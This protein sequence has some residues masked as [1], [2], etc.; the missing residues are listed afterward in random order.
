[1]ADTRTKKKPA[2][3]PAPSSSGSSD[4]LQGLSNW[5]QANVYHPANVAA[6]DTGRWL[7][8]EVAEPSERTGAQAGRGLA[9][10]VDTASNAIGQI[11]GIQSLSDWLQAHVYNP[12]GS[13][14]G[15]VSHH[16]APGLYPS[17]TSDVTAKSKPK[18]KAKADTSSAPQEV[19]FDLTSALQQAVAPYVNQLYQQLGVGT[20]AKGQPTG[21]ASANSE[22]PGGLAQYLTNVPANIAQTLTSGLNNEAQANQGMGA[23][24]TDQINNAGQAGLLTDL[25]NAAK[26]QAIYK[27]ADFAPSPSPSTPLG[28]LYT[29]VQNAGNALLTGSTSL[30]SG[31][32]SPNGKVTGT[33]NPYGQPAP[34]L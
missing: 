7:N 17:A 20:N 21:Q 10:A 31:T 15:W 12:L 1:M 29:T 22:I 13:G 5:L 28:Q 18:A 23:A 16:V 32:K 27:Q 14:E 24:I 11:P 8:Q 34:S 2:V 26:Y 30:P 6:R 4:P 19:P 25:L 33:H 9:Q 3:K